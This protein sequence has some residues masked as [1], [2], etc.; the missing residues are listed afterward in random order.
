MHGYLSLILTG[1]VP[2]LRAAGREPAGEDRL[3][4]LIAH[5]IV[6]TLNALYDARELGAKLSVALAYAPVLLEQL[7]DNVV[8]KH[9][10]VWM[11]RWL[12]A[13]SAELTRWD[14]GEQRHLAYLA[15]FYL[16]WGQGILHSFVQRFGRN[17]VAAL[18]ELCADG[19]AEPLTSAATHAYL[20]LLAR[21]ASLR[22]QL[23][24]GALSV[25]R[26]LGRRP[27]GAWLPE[28]GFAPGMEPA[29]RGAG[30]RYMVLDPASAFPAPGLTHLRPRMAASSHLVAFL[31]D[32]PACEH[33]YSAALGYPGD[34]LYRAPRRDGD[35]GLVLW[36]V[37]GGAAPELYD[38]YEAFRRAE[39]H[40]AHFA[41]VVAAE[42]EGF[43][44]RHD[45]PGIAVVPLD[46]ELLGLGWF[47]GPLWLRALLARLAE[48]P[49]VQLTGPSAYLRRHR[50]RQGVALRDGSWGPGGD[51][52][53]W[54]APAAGSLRLAVAEAEER[55][56]QLVRRYPDAH[57][58]RERL[59]SQ[60]LREL[61]LAQSSDW[62]P[63]HS[64]PADADADRPLA[65]LRRC[66]QLCALA[67]GEID[68]TAVAY[69]E[70]IEE[71]DNPFPEL[72][73]RVF[74]E[75]N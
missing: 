5:A 60:A 73:Y 7:A 42:L 49:T 24:V 53:A 41:Q 4:E 46:A 67:A 33:V 3:H 30:A 37:G 64:R 62:L 66:E 23:E 74:L 43:G 11:E 55:L 40:A 26:R 51:H 20:P 9:F 19:T 61:L 68:E 25:A 16:D 38:P 35:P 59:L 29:V 57:G 28:C 50:P 63:V 10:V 72:N 44:R 31:R 1:H 14:Q 2:Y 56:A 48:H 18:R 39:D 32:A 65:H 8:Q 21:R 52:R 15:R 13:R 6:P 45:R 58:V 17:P 54:L 36:R 47:E 75:E 70:E 34:P 22:A 71:L 27:A 12:E 69:L